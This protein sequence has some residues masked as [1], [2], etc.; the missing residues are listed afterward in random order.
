MKT[1]KEYLQLLKENYAGNDLVIINIQ[2]ALNNRIY[3]DKVEFGKWYKAN[4]DD[5]KDVYYYYNGDSASD[6]LNHVK[7]WVNRELEIDESWDNNHAMDISELEA[8][9]DGLL[10]S[11][12]A[13]I[14]IIN[15]GKHILANNA[16][17]ITYLKGD[18][19]QNLFINDTFK[20]E[21]I[22]GKYKFTLP[23]NL[24][25]DL[26][27]MT[28]P[29]LVGGLNNKSIRMFRIILEIINKNYTILDEWVF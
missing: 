26:K 22:K 21:L 8:H 24:I 15:V 29:F 2:P 27:E 19:I 11:N 1:F 6:N 18:V 10:E 28:Q 12:Y 16:D 7:Q 3:F 5:F 20:D 25:E 14:D 9:F 4:K 23:Y 13:D 17:K